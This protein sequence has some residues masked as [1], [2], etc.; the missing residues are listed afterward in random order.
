MFLYA[1]HEMNYWFLHI[2]IGVKIPEEY[3]IYFACSSFFSGFI[4]K[5][6][7]GER[8]DNNVLIRVYRPGFFDGS[9][10]P[11]FLSQRS[12]LLSI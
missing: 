6:K 12:L 10:D 9:I 4:S 11:L 7:Y 2:L 3:T 1:L 5:W 8:L